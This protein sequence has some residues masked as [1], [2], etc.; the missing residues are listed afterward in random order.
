MASPRL[1]FERQG[2]AANQRYI[3]RG[4]AYSIALENNAKAALSL[5]SGRGDALA[6]FSIAFQNAQAI[7]QNGVLNAVSQIPATLSGAAIAR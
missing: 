2:T 1:A 5:W 3:A 6:S 4:R 7:G